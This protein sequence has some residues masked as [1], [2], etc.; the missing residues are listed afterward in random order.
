M[1]VKEIGLEDANTVQA[2]AVAIAI[3]NPEPLE[4]GT[5]SADADHK[6]RRGVD[7]KSH[8]EKH[9]RASTRSLREAA[10]R[11]NCTLCNI[12]SI[13]VERNSDDDV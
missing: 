11:Q 6:R 9:T 2:P 13:R 4:T 10:P 12:G 7:L 8:V 1:L 3:E 5:R